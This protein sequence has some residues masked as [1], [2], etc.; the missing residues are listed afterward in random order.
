MIFVI[1]RIQIR[2]PDRQQ[3]VQFQKSQESGKSLH[4]NGQSYGM[5]LEEEEEEEM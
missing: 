2:T 3:C 1:V 4:P 5:L